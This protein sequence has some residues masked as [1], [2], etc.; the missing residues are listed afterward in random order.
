MQSSYGLACAG[1][2]MAHNVLLHLHHIMCPQSSYNFAWNWFVVYC[3][4]RSDCL[5][6]S[7]TVCLKSTHPDLYQ[8]L[9]CISGSTTVCEEFYAFGPA[10]LKKTH[11]Q[12]LHKLV[13]KQEMLK[14]LKTTDQRNLQKLAHCVWRDCACRLASEHSQLWSE[15]WGTLVTLSTYVQSVSKLDSMSCPESC[16]VKST[17]QKTKIL[18]EVSR[19]GEP[20]PLGYAYQQKV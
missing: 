8:V 18:Q 11:R 4:S 12:N 15:S 9:P 13:W 19:F 5:L 17:A 2:Q 1:S 14:R 7:Q 6:Q 20:Q 3:F 16:G 10:C